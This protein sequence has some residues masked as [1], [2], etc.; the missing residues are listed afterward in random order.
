MDYLEHAPDMVLTGAEGFNLKANPK[1]D[2]L[3]NKG[4]FSGKHTLEN[5]FLLVNGS[6]EIGIIP[7]DSRIPDVAETTKN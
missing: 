3:F 4:I 6:C 5:T 2:K 1:A 7:E